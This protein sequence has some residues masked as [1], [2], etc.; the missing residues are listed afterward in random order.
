MD[1]VGP[2]DELA[3]E[4]F[5][6]YLEHYKDLEI[7]AIATAATINEWLNRALTDHPREIAVA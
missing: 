1:N 6:A 7:A 2:I 5:A 4:L 3:S